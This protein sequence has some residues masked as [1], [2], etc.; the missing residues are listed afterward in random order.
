LPDLR[1][2]AET[3]AGLGGES[4]FIGFTSQNWKQTLLYTCLYCTRVGTMSVVW[5]LESK[6]RQHEVRQH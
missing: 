4:M 2:A 3:E 5:K 1:L 6:V